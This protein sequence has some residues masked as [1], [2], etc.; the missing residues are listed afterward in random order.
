MQKCREGMRALVARPEPVEPTSRATRAACYGHRD[1]R[2]LLEAAFGRDDPQAAAVEDGAS[3]DVIRLFT[4]SKVG[5][6]GG[7]SD[8]AQIDGSDAAALTSVETLLP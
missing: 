8:S 4:T 2:Q 6:G 3:V 5:G 7:G 1:A